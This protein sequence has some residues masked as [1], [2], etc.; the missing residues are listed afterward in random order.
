MRNFVKSEKREPLQKTLVLAREKPFVKLTEASE[1]FLKAPSL[2]T[3][4]PRG[5]KLY[6]MVMPEW[7]EQQARKFLRGCI[8]N[9]MSELLDTHHLRGGD[10]VLNQFGCS[11]R[12]CQTW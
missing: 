12:T 6:V 3:E 8:I 4:K 1:Y 5:P 7:T 10:L 9:K 11:G 2:F